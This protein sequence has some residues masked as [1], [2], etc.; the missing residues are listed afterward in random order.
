MPRELRGPTQRGLSVRSLG[1]TDFCAVLTASG[2]LTA[3]LEGTTPTEQRARQRAAV[4]RL[5]RDRGFRLRVLSAY[6]WRCAVTGWSAPPSLSHAL[7]DAAHVVPVARGGGDGIRNGVALT[8]TVHRLFDAGVVGFSLE[9]GTWRL[10][11]RVPQEGFCLEGPGGS[12]RLVEGQPLILP[13]DPR[14]WPSPGGR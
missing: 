6:G 11:R 1:W 5:V 10:R 4:E 14:L 12:L 7:L 2:L 13:A 8:P 9:D 3:P